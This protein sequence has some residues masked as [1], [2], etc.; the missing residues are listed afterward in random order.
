[1]HWT[2][3]PAGRKRMKQIQQQLHHPQTEVSETP[4]TL[5]SNDGLSVTHT[6]VVHVHG[7]E[8]ILTEDEA[9]QLRVAL[10]SI[11]TPLQE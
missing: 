1:M 8:V 9:H 3:T 5:T 11:M 10:N 4:N 6:I 7:Q 2:Q